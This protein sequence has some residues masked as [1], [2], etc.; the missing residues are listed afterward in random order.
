[1]EKT[2]TIDGRDVR[3]QA[4]AALPYQY[5]TKFGH[6]LFA[7]LRQADAVGTVIM[8][9]LIWAMAYSADKA[10]APIEK[11]LESFGGM[12]VYGVFNELSE[13]FWASFKGVSEKN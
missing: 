9:Q 13:L 10:I 12:D 3:F 1:M 2:I 4:T 6:D 5:A 7:D 11:W 8:Y